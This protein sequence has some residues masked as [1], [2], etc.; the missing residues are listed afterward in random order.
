M[1][2]WDTKTRKTTIRILYRVESKDIYIDAGQL[3]RVHDITEFDIL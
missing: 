1:V 3:W 2:D